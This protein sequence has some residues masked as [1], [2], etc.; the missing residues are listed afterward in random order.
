MPRWLKPNHVKAY[1]TTINNIVY[2]VIIIYS[3]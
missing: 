3:F 2:E 1:E